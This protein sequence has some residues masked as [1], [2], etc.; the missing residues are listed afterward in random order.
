MNIE[1]ELDRA[2]EEYLQAHKLSTLLIQDTNRALCN[3]DLVV[4]DAAE[5]MKAITAKTELDRARKECLRVLIEDISA[6]EEDLELL[7]A[8][9]E[10]KAIT[11]KVSR[12]SLMIATT[13]AGFSL[14]AIFGVSPIVAA[15]CGVSAGYKSSREGVS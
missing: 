1:T 11:P 10:M 15:G 5:K 7:K 4:R 12:F 9:M 14:A 2:K 6:R 8:A 13:V 3:Q